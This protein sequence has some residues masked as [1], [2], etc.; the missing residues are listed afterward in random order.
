MCLF[1]GKN[2]LTSDKGNKLRFWVHWKL[3]RLTYHDMNILDAGQFDKV[4]WE[5]VHALLW[6]VPQMFQIWACKQ[7]MNISPANANIPWVNS[8]NSLCPSCAQVPETCL[9][10]LHC[11]NAGRVDALLKSI[12]LLDTWLEEV[13][14]D[15]DLCDC[16]IEYTKGT[17]SVWMTDICRGKAQRYASMAREQDKIGLCRFMEGMV[18]KGMRNIQE[19]YTQVKGSNITSTQWT[20]GLFIKL[21]E[22]THSQWLYRCMQFHDKVSG[23]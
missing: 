12:D 13:D 15:C 2:K 5:M 8:I 6:R 4:D 22:A 11:N 9:H 7:V 19:T 1:L 10:I 20:Q 18:C 21:L 16:I 17:G 23:T 3:A 14:T